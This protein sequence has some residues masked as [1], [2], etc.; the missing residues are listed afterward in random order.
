[1]YTRE[2]ARK[3]VNNL[4]DKIFKLEDQVD[5]LESSLKDK[6]RWVKSREKDLQNEKECHKAEVD[7]LRKI[8]E[9]MQR[10]YDRITSH[11]KSLEESY[12]EERENVLTGKIDIN[13]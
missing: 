6:E 12:R 4:Y 3:E 1:M 9:E 7:N 2:K 10:D 8:I 11:K 5:H 13:Q